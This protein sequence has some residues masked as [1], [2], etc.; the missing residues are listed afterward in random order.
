[1]PCSFQKH[2]NEFLLKNGESLS[3]K[4]PLHFCNALEAAQRVD[5]AFGVNSPSRRYFWS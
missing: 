1:M 3:V 5:Y 2:L 4:S